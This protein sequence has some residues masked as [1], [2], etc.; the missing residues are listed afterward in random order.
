LSRD[1]PNHHKRAAPPDQ[2]GEDR[3]TVCKEDQTREE[4]TE[5]LLTNKIQ[6]YEKI[7]DCHSSQ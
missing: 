5:I 7:N 4:S 2:G 1:S 3:Q 6:R